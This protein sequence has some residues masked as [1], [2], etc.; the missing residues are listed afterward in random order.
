MTSKSMDEHKH[1]NSKQHLI[2]KWWMNAELLPPSNYVHL[3]AIMN[4]KG[5]GETQRLYTAKRDK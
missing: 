1:I 5:L 3:M 4:V 2:T